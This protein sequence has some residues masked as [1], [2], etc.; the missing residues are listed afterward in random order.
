MTILSE[1]LRKLSRSPGHHTIYIYSKSP[2]TQSQIQNYLPPTIRC[3]VLKR[4]LAED[5]LF[6]WPIHVL[7]FF[8]TC[9]LNLIVLGG[10]RL[11]EKYTPLY[12]VDIYVPEG[13]DLQNHRNP[14]LVEFK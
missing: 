10:M 13:R 8:L 2:I 14:M 5:I 3:N 1:K 7:Y 9:G 12:I 11:Y 6:I 4:D